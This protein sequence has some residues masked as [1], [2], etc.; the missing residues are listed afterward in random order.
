MVTIHKSKLEHLFLSRQLPALLNWNMIHEQKNK[1][2]IFRQLGVPDTSNWNAH[3]NNEDEKQM[4]A[5]AL[6]AL[7]PLKECF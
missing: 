5:F 4:A 3:K 6:T 7:S 1:H 2:Y